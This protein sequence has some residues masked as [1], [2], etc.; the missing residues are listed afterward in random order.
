MFSISVPIL[1]GRSY[2]D[3]AQTQFLVVPTVE[4]WQT[5]RARMLAAD[6][7]TICDRWHFPWTG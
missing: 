3:P 2:I 4:G 7:I 6:R 5:D 1:P